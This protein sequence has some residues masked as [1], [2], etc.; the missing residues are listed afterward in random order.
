MIFFLRDD[1]G[2]IIWTK[3]HYVAEYDGIVLSPTAIT[4]QKMTNSM[5]GLI[6]QTIIPR[7]AN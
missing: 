2:T 3:A 6:T 7:L 4:K 5:N 1:T